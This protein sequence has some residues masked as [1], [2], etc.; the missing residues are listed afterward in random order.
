L[1]A[2]RVLDET[3]KSYEAIPDFGTLYDGVPV[4]AARADVQFYV[5][6]AAQVEGAVLE[7]GC[8]TGRVLLP[9]ARAGHAVVGLNASEQVLARC[10]AKLG[11]EPEVVRNRIALHRADAR[12]FHLAEK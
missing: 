3:A 8:G 1:S 9:L 12:T 2:S 7:I 11:D 6:E 10:R 4:Y 5:E